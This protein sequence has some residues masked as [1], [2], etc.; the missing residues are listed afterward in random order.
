MYSCGLEQ[1][2]RRQEED[3]VIQNVFYVFVAYTHTPNTPKEDK[4][5]RERERER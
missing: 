4:R 3:G 1:R 5:E 2:R